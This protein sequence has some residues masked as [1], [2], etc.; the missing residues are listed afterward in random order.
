MW[1]NSLE[2]IDLEKNQVA[3]ALDYLSVIW[4][5]FASESDKQ[6]QSKLYVDWNSFLCHSLLECFVILFF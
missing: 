2:I 3:P 1:Y 4:I 6:L 5:G